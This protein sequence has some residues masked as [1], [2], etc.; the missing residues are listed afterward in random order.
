M[1]EY[2]EAFSTYESSNS[3]NSLT[4][5]HYFNGT[6]GGMTVGRQLGL[7]VFSEPDDQLSYDNKSISHEIITK[8]FLDFM[9]HTRQNESMLYLKSLSAI[10]SSLDNTFKAANKAT[11]T[12]KDGQ[13]AREIKGG[14]LTVLNCHMPFWTLNSKSASPDIRI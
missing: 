9:T 7:Q 4:L 2:L 11:L 5:G 10:C 3:S 13:K 12:N 8:V 1:L 14:I 6:A